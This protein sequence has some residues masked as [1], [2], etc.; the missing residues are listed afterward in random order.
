M[1]GGSSITA[2]TRIRPPHQAQARKPSEHAEGARSAG[3][4]RKRVVLDSLSTRAV[5]LASRGGRGERTKC[6]ASAAV[7]TRR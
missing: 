3:A 1:A 4:E 5:N 7:N 2:M 6:A